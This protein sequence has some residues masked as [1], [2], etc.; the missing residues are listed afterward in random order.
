[1]A[2]MLKDGLAFLTSQLRAN[3]SQTVTYTRGPESID[4]QATFGKKLLKINDQFGGV[5]LEWTDMDFLIP[6]ADVAPIL[7]DPKNPDDG[8][9]IFVS[10]PDQNQV[11]VY[12]VEH[13]ES[14]SPWMWSDPHQ[15]MYRIHG[16]HVRTD[17]IPY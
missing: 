5:R 12:I 2:D 6:A 11:Q 3:A 14:E 4:V 16:K 9:L 13:I 7:I 17:A 15:S 10:Q 1:M 8:D